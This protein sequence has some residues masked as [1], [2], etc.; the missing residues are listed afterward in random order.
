MPIPTPSRPP[1]DLAAEKLARAYGLILSWP[2]PVCGRP[3]PCPC[4]LAETPP[5]QAETPQKDKTP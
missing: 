5:A 2:C 4:D 1:A 3:F